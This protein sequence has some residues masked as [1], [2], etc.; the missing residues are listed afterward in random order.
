[1]DAWLLQECGYEVK[2]CFVS[3][4]VFVFHPARW[5]CSFT[6]MILTNWA[7][8]RWH[9]CTWLGDHIADRVFTFSFDYFQQPI[10]WPEFAN[11]HPFV[12]VEQAAGYLEMMKELEQDLCEITGFDAISFQPNRWVF[13]VSWSTWYL[14]P[15]GDKVV[16]IE[17]WRFNYLN[18]EAYCKFQKSW[19]P[20]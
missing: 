13:K 3:N 10:T 5:L 17:L 2:P 18:R 4:F 14:S 19:L 1:M 8:V 15:D 11:I 7:F 6:E 9:S 20:A 16:L 12:P